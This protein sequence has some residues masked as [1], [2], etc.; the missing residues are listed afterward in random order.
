MARGEWGVGL[1][2]G[3][4]LVSTLVVGVAVLVRQRSPGEDGFLAPPWVWWV[5]FAVFLGVLLLDARVPG[6]WG[7][8][9]WLAALCLGAVAIYLLA[10]GS[11]VTPVCLITSAASAAFVLSTR[12]TYAVVAAQTGVL[13]L[14][15]VLIG[16]SGSDVLTVAGLFGGFQFFA[17]LMALT[18]LRESRTRAELSEVNAELR[19]TQQKLRS[20]AKADERLRISRDLHDLVGHQLTAL[21]LEL[22]VASHHTG[23][24]AAQH[25]DRARRTA[26]ELLA[27]LRRAVGQLRA[28]PGETSELLGAVTGI[29]KP[30]VHL[31]IDDDIEFTD[32]EQAHTLVRCV[33][34]IVT[35]TVRHADADHLWITVRRA[36]AELLVDAH[37]D[38]CGAPQV[39]PGNGL[40][41]MRERL[42]HLG[43]ELRYETAPDRGFRLAA[44]LP[45]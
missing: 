34:E 38:G 19:A 39:R 10:P 15:Q 37:D 5:A 42:E 45:T 25:V 31:D 33:Q 27:D 3:S 44:R 36:G 30:E 40:T 22:E 43:G 24:D 41:G 23:G 32:A 28:A 4:A 16:S 18:A 9:L 14:G 13:A 17:T 26:K 12:G 6:E 11:M 21:A 2:L 35:N 8:E 29:P 20:S 1:R 7:A